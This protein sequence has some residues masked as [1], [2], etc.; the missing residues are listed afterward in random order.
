MDS[1]PSQGD[2]GEATI[3]LTIIGAFDGVPGDTVTGN[4]N[5]DLPVEQ[6]VSGHLDIR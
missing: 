2:A 3:Q 6:V 5:Y 1:A 4:G